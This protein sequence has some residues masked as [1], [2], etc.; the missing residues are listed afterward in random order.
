LAASVGIAYARPDDTADAVLN[1]A[2]RV[3]YEAKRQGGN[4]FVV[5]DRLSA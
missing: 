1:N 5:S 2:D 4:R 3:M